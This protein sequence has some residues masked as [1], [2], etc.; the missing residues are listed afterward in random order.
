VSTNK[1]INEAYIKKFRKEL[2]AMLN[3]ISEIDRK[4]LNK[5]LLKGIRFV[6]RKDVTPVDTSNLQKNWF[7]RHAVKTPGGVE[8][9]LYNNAE[10]APY[11]NYGHRVKNKNGETVGFIKGRYMIE[12]TVNEIDKALIQ[13]FKLEV[14]RVNR[15]HDK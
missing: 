1:R 12:R 11:V 14:E 4:V 7:I 8:G 15:K 13:G 10:Y 3:D 9:E 6:K 2:T 5:A